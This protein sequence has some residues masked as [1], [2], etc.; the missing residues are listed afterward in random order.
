MREDLER[1][2]VEGSDVFAIDTNNLTF[3]LLTDIPKLQEQ[4]R[5]AVS[6][7]PKV[8]DDE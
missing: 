7:N 1:E 3:G 6:T 2:Y 4:A 5:Q 8:P